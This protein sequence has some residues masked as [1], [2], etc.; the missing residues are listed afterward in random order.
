MT[1]PM[2]TQSS[3]EKISMTA[4]MVMK[5]VE[6]KEKKM[7]TM[8]FILPEKYRKTEEELRPVDKR[9]VIREKGERKY[10]VVKFGGMVTENVVVKKVEELRKGYTLFTGFTL[11]TAITEWSS[12]LYSIIYTSF[13]T[14]F[15][16][17]LDKDLSRMTLLRAIVRLAQT[18][19]FWLCLL[20]IPIKAL[21][22]RFVVK[23]FVQYYGAD[24]I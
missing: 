24:D 19:L 23:N 14:I 15:V 12:V 20:G 22:P 17:I 18:G 2:I 13:P 6:D 7:M 9:A 8:Q 10:G 21:I 3:P 11:T 16:G 5:E 1:A 4:P